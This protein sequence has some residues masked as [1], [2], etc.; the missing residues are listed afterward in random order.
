MIPPSPSSPHSLQPIS[1]NRFDPFSF[2]C[3]TMTSIF[4]TS[5]KRSGR[6]PPT[7]N[8]IR[9]FI[10]RSKNS[11][12][13]TILPLPLT[14]PD[15]FNYEDVIAPRI[16]ETRR[17]QAKKRTFQASIESRWNITLPN[18]IPHEIAPPRLSLGLLRQLHRLASNPNINFPQALIC[19]RNKIDSRLRNP[20]AKPYANKPYLLSSDIAALFDETRPEY[21]ELDEAVAK[22]EA[23]PAS[24]SLIQQSNSSSTPSTDSTQQRLHA[25]GIHNPFPFPR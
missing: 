3:K 13:P 14:V 6:L 17:V 7:L 5:C 21:I 1:F 4:S 8:S 2:L 23:V 22:D 18:A 12:V 15:S 24:T 10:P 11:R 19:I 20:T 9:L 25:S 16:T